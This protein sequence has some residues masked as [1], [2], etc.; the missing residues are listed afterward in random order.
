[1]PEAGDRDVATLQ[2]WPENWADAEN[3]DSYA[4]SWRVAATSGGDVRFQ[5]ERRTPQGTT[6]GML[7]GGPSGA[8]DVDAERLRELAVD[9]VIRSL[10]DHEG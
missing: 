1:V 8:A 7:L 4:Y 3:D 10:A 5:E 6:S 2:Y 9:F